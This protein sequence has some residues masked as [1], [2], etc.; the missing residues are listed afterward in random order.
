MSGGTAGGLQAA[1][2]PRGNTAY[3]IPDRCPS[4]LH[5]QTAADQLSTASPGKTLQGFSHQS[6]GKFFP[7]TYEIHQTVSN[8]LKM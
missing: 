8:H 7:K 1:P 2:K 4:N 3:V 6:A 5:L